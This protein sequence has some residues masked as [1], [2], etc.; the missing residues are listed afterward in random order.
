MVVIKG[1]ALKDDVVKLQAFSGLTH[2][3]TSSPVSESCC[4]QEFVEFHYV[5]KFN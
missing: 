5:G 2:L 3:L 4:L 1:E